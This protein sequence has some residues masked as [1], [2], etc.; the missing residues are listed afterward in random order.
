MSKHKKSKYNK[1]VSQSGK[2]IR[3]YT[4]CDKKLETPRGEESITK[5]PNRGQLHQGRN[6][7]HR[8][9]LEKIKMESKII[10]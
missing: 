6:F 4:D 2:H 3:I 5:R 10:S 8:Y 1:L 7:I 9:D